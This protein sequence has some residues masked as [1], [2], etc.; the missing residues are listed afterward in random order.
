MDG[1][2]RIEES[3]VS[4]FLHPVKSN[5]IAGVARIKPK[6]RLPPISLGT[7]QRCKVAIVTLGLKLLSSSFI[8]QVAERLKQ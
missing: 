6:S 4:V 5:T 1:Q 2:D 8:D 3:V 7:G